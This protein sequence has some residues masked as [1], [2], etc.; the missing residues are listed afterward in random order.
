MKKGVIFIFVFVFFAS[1]VAAEII[2]GEAI[3]T[4]EVISSEVGMTISVLGSPSLV[5]LSPKNE[6]YLTRSIL[7]NYVVSGEDAV[8]YSLNGGSNITIISSGKI[9]VESGLNS[10]YLYANNSYGVSSKVVVFNVDESRLVIIYDEYNGL[11]KGKSTDFYDI[12]YED[13]QFLE[14]VVLE[15]S[16]YGKISFNDVINVTDDLDSSDNIVDLDGYI[17]ISP[18]TISIDSVALPNFNK[19][20]TLSFYG[21]SFSNPR[22]LINGEVCPSFLCDV[23]GYSGG[24][25]EFNVTHFTTY[26]VEETPDGAVVVSP[27]S[28][29]G[30]SRL[31]K[32][33][34]LIDVE[35]IGVKIKQGR[36]VTKKIIITN[37]ENRKMFVNLRVSDFANVVILNPSFF[38]LEPLESKEIFID[39]IVR[40]NMVP[41][42]YIGKIIVESENFEK[43]ILFSIVV[44][45]EVEL[46]DVSVSI[47]ADYAEVVA[48]KDLLSE[49]ELFN[50]GETGRIDA[51][52]KY[53]IKNSEG[54]TI[55]LEEEVKAVETSL[56][57]VKSF[58]IPS[59]LPPGKYIIYVQVSY[60]DQVIGASAWFSVVEDDSLENPLALTS[61]ESL[62]NIFGVIIVIAIIFIIVIKRLGIGKRKRK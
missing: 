62:K 2:T 13:L 30:S 54:E 45:S 44:E 3:A 55:V 38:V 7:L 4:G 9:D 25:F 6:V 37:N 35:Q 10:L 42:I 1:Y 21:L 23:I 59:D 56:N 36:I 50:F 14:G 51:E 52:I 24:T 57:F 18:N 17:D 40:E 47:P 60:S 28:G 22:A 27:G 16:S 31:D 12:S 29:R 61:G 15:R 58:R 19:P 33:V 53:F 43:E 11:E 32:D 26:S 20:A 48:G 49:I 39:F 46:F 34:L 8:W 41:D 5:I